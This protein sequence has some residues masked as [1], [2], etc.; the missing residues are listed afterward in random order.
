[1]LTGI[2]M[3]KNMV[4]GLATCTGM[5]ALHKQ[6]R[7]I[8]IKDLFIYPGRNDIVPASAGNIFNTKSLHMRARLR[9]FVSGLFA[10]LILQ[11]L[12]LSA[13]SDLSRYRANY[14][15][16]APSD[17]S[18]RIIE[19]AAHVI[20]TARQ[21][22]WQQ[23]ELTAFFHFGMNTFTGTEWGTGKEDPKNFNPS[24]LNVRQWVKVVK[25]AGFKQVI[26]TAKHHDGF[27]LW[28]T[29]TTKHSVASSPWQNGKGDVVKELSR[30]CWEM[31][32]GFG[33]YLSPWDRNSALYGTEAYNDFFYQAV[34]RIADT[35]RAD[36]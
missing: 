24:D 9:F 29:K 26:L 16:I 28:P 22:K 8:F 34:D 6:Q 27:C 36:R 30:A 3:I 12:Q 5:E 23:L 1:M 25:E 7:E 2:F 10:I 11:S 20:P 4:N 15:V 32:M 31:G 35:V 21:L 14:M 13:Q 17:D 33:I 19:K 18:L